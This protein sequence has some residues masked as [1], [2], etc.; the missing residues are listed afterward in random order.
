MWTQAGGITITVAEAD[1]SSISQSVNGN[2]VTLTL[3]GV[4]SLDPDLTTIDGIS[5]TTF[6]ASHNNSVTIVGNKLICD[7]SSWVIGSYQV[8]LCYLDTS[9]G[10]PIPQ[11]HSA[12]IKV[13]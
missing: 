3:S 4:P 11:S 8:T 7:T 2:I 13:E 1:Y 5:V 6:N 12:T 9:M 10:I